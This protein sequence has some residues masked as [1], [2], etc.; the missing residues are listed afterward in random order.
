MTYNPRKQG[1][2]KKHQA[3]GQIRGNKSHHLLPD[4]WLTHEEMHSG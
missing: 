2:Q 3:G 4:W 1:K